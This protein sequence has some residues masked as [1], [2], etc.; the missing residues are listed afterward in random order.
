MSLAIKRQSRL[1]V[2]TIFRDVNNI[3]Y[4]VIKVV[5]DK[6]NARL[7]TSNGWKH[8][9]RAPTEDERLLSDVLQT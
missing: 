7:G 9:V 8:F 3:V 1:E 5:Y 6:G 2:G 4:V